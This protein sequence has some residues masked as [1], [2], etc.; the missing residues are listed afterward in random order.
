MQ[1][2]TV[3]LPQNLK[4]QAER[5]AREMGISLGELIRESL[6]TMINRSNEDRPTKDPLFTDDAV[7]IGEAPQD[8]SVHHDEY[9][10]GERK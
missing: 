9:L 2:T 1:R 7:Y 6:E 5:Y 4:L 3:M 10:Y 8:I